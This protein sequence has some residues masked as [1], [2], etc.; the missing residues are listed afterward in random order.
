L[1]L[2]AAFATLSP[3]GE[4][5]RRRD[6][7]VPCFEALPARPFSFWKRSPAALSADAGKAANREE[8]RERRRRDLDALVELFERLSEPAA[9]PPP[10]REKLRYLLALALCRKK[11]LHLVELARTGGADCL[12]IRTSGEAELVSV[13]AP[14]LSAEDLERL[15]GELEGEMG[16]A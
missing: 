2:A 11:R 6:Y 8:K 1:G 7:C 9:E 16:L 10:E 14:A 5:F 12:V 4:G 3:E 15:A 13:P